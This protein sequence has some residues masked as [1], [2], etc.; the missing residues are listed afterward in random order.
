MFAGP[1]T[2]LSSIVFGPPISMHATDFLKKQ[3]DLNAIP[4]MALFGAERYLKVQVLNSIPGFADDED[5]DDEAT[6]TRLT[7]KDADLRTVT[8]ELSTVSMFGGRRIVVIDSA[9]DFVSANRNG[10]ET[11]ASK[12]SSSSL[13]VLDVTSWA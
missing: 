4:M 7:G 13:L 8:D 12:A 5:S 1:L 11:Y 2:R 3:P 6:V 9:D 10:L